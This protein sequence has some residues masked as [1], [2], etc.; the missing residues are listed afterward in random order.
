MNYV[1]VIITNQTDGQINFNVVGATKDKKKAEDKKTFHEKFASDN[2]L[3]DIF[4]AEEI[5]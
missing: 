5:L 1:V 4:E 2:Q 3:V